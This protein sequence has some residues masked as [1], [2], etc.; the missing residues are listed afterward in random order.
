MFNKKI[1][2]GNVML[3]F[4]LV[5][6]ILILSYINIFKLDQVVHSDVVGEIGLAKAM[7]LEKTILPKDWFYST[8]INILRAPLLMLP[9]YYMT[10]NW[11]LAFS[12]SCIIIMIGYLFSFWFM[13]KPLIKN[14]LTMLIG[15]IGILCLG[16][17]GG[18]SHIIFLYGA[19]YGFNYICLMLCLGI[20]IRL[21]EESENVKFQYIAIISCFVSFV[22]GIQ[23]VKMLQILCI[24]LILVEII[25]KYIY[26]Q[27]NNKRFVYTVSIFASNFIGASIAKTFIVK[28]VNLGRDVTSSNIV[29]IGE[30]FNRIAK[31]FIETMNLIN[32]GGGY[33]LIS[34]NSVNMF[35]SM[36]L[37]F[38]CVII[39][40][41]TIINKQKGWEIVLIIGFSI[42]ITLLSMIFI[43]IDI[44]ARYLSLIIVLIDISIMICIDNIK[45]EHIKLK[46]ILIIIF[47]FTCCTN[48]KVSYSNILLK[49][50]GNIGYKKITAYL[51]AND[52]DTVYA[53]YWNSGVLSS[54]SN[55][56]LITG[57]IDPQNLSVYK[58]LTSTKDYAPYNNSK[59]VAIILTDDEEKEL[60]D[61]KNFILK[62][63]KKVSEIDKY[64]IYEYN[65]NPIFLLDLNM[66]IGDEQVLNFNN[67]LFKLAKDIEVDNNGYI[68]N[69]EK[70]SEY[71]VY[72]P[73]I[74]VNQGIF[75]VELDY[76]VGSKDSNNDIGH[77][78][79][80]SDQGKKILSKE[81]IK[82]QSK[83]SVL[84]N[85]QLI[86]QKNVEFRIYINEGNNV[87]LKSIKITR[88]S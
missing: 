14:K 37:L 55:G 69:N 10:K 52:Y 44:A 8:E 64:N 32:A 81:I 7:Y 33:K 40:I 34:L 29:S 25:K 26:K 31:I 74:D 15:S 23:S 59:K 1:K 51:Q 11:N 82:E 9:I 50:D 62:N 46:N 58:W 24:P 17:T 45:E 43:N 70:K 20:Y 2:L 3:I 76:E 66:K 49:S 57:N 41:R 86:K 67:N 65:Q 68:I 16:K 30:I 84:N 4:M 12:I 53:S 80:S 75:N 60:I 54:I 22:F 6:I 72:G 39:S 88:I 27:N 73:N 85:V 77:F 42:L 28:I 79:I 63:R 48:F 36:S 38:I 35:L 13:M 78:E 21:N 56:K 5:C 71:V 19:Y 47:L 87:I 61:N 83:K 18:Y